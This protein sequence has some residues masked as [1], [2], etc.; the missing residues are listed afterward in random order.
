VSAACRRS[1]AGESFSHDET[2]MS[3][4]RALDDRVQLRCPLCLAE[5]V[6][7]TD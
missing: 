4:A 6:V 1:C 5:T 7:L 2:V 3:I